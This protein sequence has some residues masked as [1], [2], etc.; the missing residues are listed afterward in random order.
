M[1]HIFQYTFVT[2][3]HLSVVSSVPR[4]EYQKVLQHLSSS[5]EYGDEANP[6]SPRRGKLIINNYIKVTCGI[7]RGIGRI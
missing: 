7:G 1:L 6:Y 4:S 2:A 5:E 3:Q